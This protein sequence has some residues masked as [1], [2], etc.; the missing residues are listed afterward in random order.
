MLRDQRRLGR[1][2]DGVG[3]IGDV[4]Q[5][6][7][8]LADIADGLSRAEA[9][10]AAR[11][12][13]LPEVTYPGELPISHRRGEIAAAIRDNQVVIV[14]GETG[15][16]K[17]TQLPK[18][19]LELGR[20]VRG[21][22]GHTQPRRIAAR[23]MADR[24]AAELGTEL[25]AV[26]GYQVRFS[27]Q[28]SEATLVKL[29]T[30]GILLAEIQSDRL[31]SRYDT[32]I[33][34]EAHE[35]SLNVDFIL[36]YLKQLLPRRRDLKVIVTSATIDPQR[37]SQHFS[38]A[39]IVEVSGRT[40]PVE[41]RYRP[42]AEE[43][44]TEDDESEANVRDQT[45]AILDAVSELCAKGP[46]DI[47][48][49]LSGEREIRD[50]ADALGKLR[51][52]PGQQIEVLPLYARLS[53]AEQHRVFAPHSG[54][55]VVLATN[56]AETSLTVPGIHYV[57]DPGTARISRY[58]HRTK[59]QRLPIERISR[60]SADQRKGRCGRV[61]RG[62]CIRL[63]SEAD[64]DSRPAFTDPEILRTSLASVI[65]Q[66]TALGLGDMAA[67]PFLEPPDR[68]D[69][70][71]GVQL[72]EELGA[73]DPSQEISQRRLTPTGRQLAQL[74]TDPRLA[75]MIVEANRNG[76]LLEVAVIAAALSI[77][78]PR[79]RPLDHQQA[80]DTAHARF[81]H[82]GSDFLGLLD[83][84]LYVRD[85][86]KA[87]SS[88]RFRRLC[89]E[90]YLNYLRIREWQDLVSQLREVAKAMNLVWSSSPADTDRIHQS[91][92]AGHLSHVGTWDAEQRNYLGAR[93][94]HFSI[95]PG[96]ALFKTQ[97][98]WVMAAELVETTK[99]WGRMVASIQPEW[100]EALSSH[101]V[102]RTYSEPHWQS[103]P[104]SVMAYERVTLYG[105]P[106]VAGRKVSYG[107]IDPELSRELFIRSALVEGDWRT[108][109]RFFH[110]NRRLLEEAEDLEHKARRRGIVVDDETLF[111]FYDERVGAE[112][113]SGRHFDVWWKAIRRE[114]PDLLTFSTAMLVD[115]AAADV[116]PHEYPDVWR[117]ESLALPV[118]Y[119]FEPGSADDGVSV[120]IP[121][122]A[123]NQVSPGEFDWQVPGLRQELVTTLI[124]SLPKTLRRN[125]VPAPNYAKAFLARVTAGEEP[126]LDALEREL[127]RTTGVRVPR[128]AWGLERLPAH[129]RATFRVV[130]DGGELVGV[131]KDLAELR[132]RFEPRLAG[133]LSEAASTVEQVGLTDWT[134]DVLP[135]TFEQTRAG[136]QVKGYP[137]LVDEGSTVAI[138]VLGTRA[139]QRAVTRTGLRR[140]LMLTVPSPVKSIQADLDNRTK[141]S[142]GLSPGVGIESLLVDCVAAA[143]DSLVEEM[144]EP[145]RDRASFEV[146]R[147]RARADL[148]RVTAEVVAEASTVLT[149][150]HEVDRRLSGSASLPMLPALA[151]MKAQ[152]AGLVHPGFVAE[153]GVTRLSF[154]PRY[155]AGIS[156]RLDRLARDLRRDAE[157][158]AVVHGIEEA[159]RGLTTAQPAGQ[160]MS[161]EVR[162]I[163]WMIEELRISLFAQA[164][165]TAEPVSEQRVWRAIN[166][167]RGLG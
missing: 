53:T 162:H 40:Y 92:L 106:L 108:G 87:L 123:L 8:A 47:L 96:S 46:G 16:G 60:A 142:L 161:D 35:R 15:S 140:L 72:L 33:V 57:V 34:D 70:K 69:V 136:H 86:R 6:A 121:L 78:D 28:S 125:F 151:D 41:L 50:T 91:V 88:N 68:R 137:A 117:S 64:F 150:A 116:S 37:F 27:D 29:M 44:N 36:G 26:V 65:L 45:Q 51:L 165:G 132:R 1:R 58:S 167:V 56:V 131:G 93:N 157:R 118:T 153:T 76:C 18:M 111:E 48:V 146:V 129:L 128:E 20:G 166:Q 143:I 110:Q 148:T 19:C 145:V 31:L 54:R 156:W 126:L 30:D 59:V 80:A 3:K 63:Y 24:I 38:D 127:L 11:R 104:A 13:G 77:Q 61:A 82:E 22:I 135:D 75:R 7:R 52:S 139:E 101:L 99:L 90:E 152:A 71:A 133:A 81:K 21:Q 89:R 10:V 134:F 138:R 122:A 113:V 120:D 79:E 115:P 114:Q 112:V 74:P 49:F 124:R 2:L 9:R 66:M 163:R 98:Q 94:A 12:A 73:I 42:L 109:H 159:F 158:M 62:V 55:R 4:Q 160:P 97:P 107:R 25:G 102:K 14:A 43:P 39:P 130:D 164:L 95:S 67:F 85:Q 5:R 147:E 32:I 155:L 141:L 149:A 144:R 103:K 17:T 100:A 119:A 154:L 83:L 23:T 105:L 84:W